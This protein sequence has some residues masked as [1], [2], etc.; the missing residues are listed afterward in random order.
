[1]TDDLARSALDVI[2]AHTAGDR[3]AFT[4]YKAIEDETHASPSELRDALRRLEVDGLIEW[5]ANG[6]IRPAERM[7]HDARAP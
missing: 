7:E 3:H 2:R 4:R 1:M 5:R 6:A